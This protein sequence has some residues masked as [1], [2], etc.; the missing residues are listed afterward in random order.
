[1]S[2]LGIDDWARLVDLRQADLEAVL[3]RC[4]QWESERDPNGMELPRAKRHDDKSL[5][6]ILS[7]TDGALSCGGDLMERRPQ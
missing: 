3:K 5:A 2:H 6:V 1:M 4:H 7:V